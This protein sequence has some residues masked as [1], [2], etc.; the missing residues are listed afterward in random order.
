MKIN[1]ILVIII[2]LVSACSPSIHEDIAEPDLSE[3]SETMEEIQEEPDDVQAED[4]EPEH[5]RY[6]SI[7]L[8]STCDSDMDYTY[9]CSQSCEDSLFY[10]RSENSYT[11]LENESVICNCFEPRIMRIIGGIPD[12]EEVWLEQGVILS[13]NES[14]DV[15]YNITLV[16]IDSAETYCIV[17]F[18]DETGRVERGKWTVI[19]DKEFGGIDVKVL[20]LPARNKNVCDVVIRSIT[21]D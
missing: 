18:N 13:F 14:D 10:L 8:D 4:E 15:N 9:L 3:Q 7:E 12:D 2:L 21:N 11:C 16:S 6:F 1:I 17:A 19:G 5:L 20:H